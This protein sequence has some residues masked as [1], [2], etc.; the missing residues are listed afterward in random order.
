MFFECSIKSFFLKFF[1]YSLFIKSFW[2]LQHSSKDVV[3]KI[4]A[5]CSYEKKKP[6][7]R[8][9]DEGYRLREQK[10]KNWMSGDYRI[11][12]Y[13]KDFFSNI[14][15]DTKALQRKYEFF[16]GNCKKLRHGQYHLIYEILIAWYKKYASANI[17]SDGPMLKEEA[18]LIKE[19]LNKDELLR[20]LHQMAG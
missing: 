19:R 13:W 6:F 4:S 2:R 3:L 7:I 20:S 8:R 15:R 11:F 14:L 9:K 18:T 16:K 17:F 1:E 5:F 10:S 12:Q